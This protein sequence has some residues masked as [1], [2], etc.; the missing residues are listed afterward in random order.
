L[1]SIRRDKGSAKEGHSGPPGGKEEE[2]NRVLMRMGMAVLLLWQLSSA[3]QAPPA[4]QRANDE[5]GKGNY[6]AALALYQDALAHPPRESGALTSE[7]KGFL[8]NQIGAC[9]VNLGRTDEAIRALTTATSLFQSAAPYTWLGFI[10]IN[11]LDYQESVRSFQK[12]IQIDPNTCVSYAGL[13]AASSRLAQYDI[14]QKAFEDGRGKACSEA[15]LNTLKSA[16]GLVYMSKRQYDEA[17]RVVGDRNLIGVDFDTRTGTNKVGFIFPGGPAELAGIVVGDIVE[18]VNEQPVKS[19]KALSAALDVIPFG[20]TI[21]IR[22]IR[23]GATEDKYVIAGI[24]TNLPELAAAANQ[25]FTGTEPAA[26]PAKPAESSAFRA[27]ATA[28]VINRVDVNPRIVKSGQRF[29]LEI[30]YTGRAKGVIVLTYTIRS[31][32]RILFTSQ[33]EMLESG[34]GTALLMTKNLT[35]ANEPGRYIFRAQMSLDDTKATG[36]TILIVENGQ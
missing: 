25:P 35:A 17:N 9:F 10:Y 30:S 13:A 32:S 33:P 21:A 27:A 18:S 7:N 31:G 6:E 2:M 12:A 15:D 23:N 36:E 19:Y 20:S 26:P 34:S 22:I 11:R 28:L 14:T 8:Y 1:I 4:V 3:Y 5:F 24:P 29:A 16:M